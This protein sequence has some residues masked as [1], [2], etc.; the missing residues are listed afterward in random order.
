[1]SLAQFFSRPLTL[2]E[3]APAYKSHPTILN[4]KEHKKLGLQVG[5]QENY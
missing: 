4:K 5:V 3:T 2:S 1:M